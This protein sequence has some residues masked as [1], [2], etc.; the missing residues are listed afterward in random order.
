MTF[1]VA[2]AGC[3]VFEMP[4]VAL[5]RVVL[6]GIVRAQ[7]NLDKLS[8]EILRIFAAKPR[9]AGRNRSREEEGAPLKEQTATS[10]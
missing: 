7:I 10:V 9:N 8:D 6:T 4:F 3:L 1:A 5:E 2:F